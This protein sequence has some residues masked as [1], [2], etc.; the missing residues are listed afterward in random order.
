MSS[1]AS[2]GA[3]LFHALRSRAPEAAAHASASPE[4]RL[5]RFVAGVGARARP[6]KAGRCWALQCTMHEMPHHRICTC[7]APC[8]Q[9]RVTSNRA[10]FGGWGVAPFAYRVQAVAACS[11]VA[12]GTCSRG[13]STQW[14]CQHNGVLPRRSSAAASPR[15]SVQRDVCRAD[16]DGCMSTGLVTPMPVKMMSAVKRVRAHCWA[17][18]GGNAC[19][20]GWQRTV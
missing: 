17:E 6:A 9:C 5:G 7:S 3:A 11:G 2:R 15:L 8:M 19:P 10:R 18:C 14:R 1:A 16:A 20:Q 4:G 13:W 12:E